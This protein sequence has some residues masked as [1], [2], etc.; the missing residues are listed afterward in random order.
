MP[1][2]TALAATTPYSR[3]AQRHPSLGLATSLA[4]E[5]RRDQ[6]PSV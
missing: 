5:P 3:Q 4:A 1:A 6:P 2:K